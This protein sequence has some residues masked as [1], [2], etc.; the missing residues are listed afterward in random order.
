[1][2]PTAAR[3][4]E[5]LRHAGLWEAIQPHLV[6][7][8]NI[9]QAAQFATSGAAQGGIVAQ[10]LALAPTLAR[11]VRFGLIAEVVAPAAAAAH[12][13]DAR[14]GAGGTRAFYDHLTTP[15]AQAVMARY[16]FAV[17]RD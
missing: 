9:S 1:M 3:A 4:E 14:R 5:A 16:G 17:P 13:A 15:A 7:G 6:L 10:S 12:G 2:R 8:E 11:L